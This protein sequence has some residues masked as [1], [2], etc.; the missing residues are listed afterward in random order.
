MWT[1]SLKRY[2]DA[3]GRGSNES[4]LALELIDPKPHTGLLPHIANPYADFFGPYE[5]S[6]A[7][8]PLA[9]L[10]S[11]ARLDR[12]YLPHWVDLESLFARL[13]AMVDLSKSS[14]APTTADLVAAI[15]LI[16]S[17][18]YSVEWVSD[19]ETTA[20]LDNDAG[21]RPYPLQPGRA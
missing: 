21:P 4:L 14:V 15:G 5:A 12:H 9:R 7:L 17:L 8:Y 1:D 11:Y 18:T 6:Q 3:I 13:L 19:S 2:L 20:D 10:G 16:G